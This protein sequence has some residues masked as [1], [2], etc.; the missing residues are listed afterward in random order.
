[1]LHYNDEARIMR[2]AVQGDSASWDVAMAG[3]GSLTARSVATA[4]EV[5]GRRRGGLLARLAFL[6]PALFA[7]MAYVTPAI[8]PPTS[9][10]VPS[11]ATTFFGS[12]WRPI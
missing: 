4:Q 11:M 3:P 5:V 9:R 10:P 7:S 8:S 12:C 6:G 2:S 1:M